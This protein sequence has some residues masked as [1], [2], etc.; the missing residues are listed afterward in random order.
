MHREARVAWTHFSYIPASSTA[1]I[2][3]AVVF[4]VV[5]EGTS[6]HSW[7]TTHTDLTL[8][9]SYAGP[10]FRFFSAREAWYDRGVHHFFSEALHLAQKTDLE[11]K[12]KVQ[13][14]GKS[15]G[16][17]TGTSIV[18]HKISGNPAIFGIISSSVEEPRQPE[19]I[20]SKRATPTVAHV[21]CRTQNTYVLIRSVR[22]ITRYNVV[23][24]RQLRGA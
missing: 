20:R 7:C 11:E 24:L 5:N 12:L 9:V 15:H 6:R 22:R 4:V 17:L 8:S 16:L 2:V 14:D 13:A 23:N 19:I 18:E 10:L 21:S 1:P 3:S